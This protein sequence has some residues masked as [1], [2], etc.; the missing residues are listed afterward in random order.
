MKQLL[1]A[2]VLMLLSISM[3]AQTPVAEYRVADGT[4]IFTINLA[5]GSKIYNISTKEFWVANAPITAGPAVNINSEG[6]S[7]TG[8][9]TLLTQLTLGAIGATD[10]KIKTT[11]TADGSAPSGQIITL[12]QA[13]AATNKAGLLSGADKSKLDNMTTGD[14]G[15]YTVE[16]T[17]ISAP[18]TSV[19]LVNT[20]KNASSILVMV[21]GVPMKVTT[22]YS[23]L[24]K[25]VTIVPPLVDNDVVTVSY[26]Y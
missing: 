18:A 1:L 12:P 11:S 6:P 26:T 4:T 14:V 20:P 10:I 8:K 15:I 9:L 17:T 13:D 24:A 2:S 25:V 21:N 23:I 16:S 19:T 22:Q 5:T 3:F 7:G